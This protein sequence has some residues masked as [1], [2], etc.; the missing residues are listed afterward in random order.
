M[1]AML[2]FYTTTCHKAPTSQAQRLPHIPDLHINHIALELPAA[3]AALPH[4]DRVAL[5]HA[6]LR[7][8]A[9]RLIQ[10]TTAC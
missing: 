8:S 1:H 2:H 6:H 10:C 3:S 7:P 9:T 5:W 4:S